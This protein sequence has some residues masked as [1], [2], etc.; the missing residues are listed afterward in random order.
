MS[1]QTVLI[2]EDNELN[3]K[4]AV[5]I[6]EP[7]GYRLLEAADAEAGLEM[8]REHRPDLILMDVQLPGMDGLTAI[9]ILKKDPELKKIPVLVLTSYAMEED[10]KRA[11]DAGADGYVTKPFVI[12]GFRDT[13][14]NLLLAGPAA[15]FATAP[16]RVC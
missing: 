3:M 10:A 8:A 11:R 16:V 4:L 7:E 15:G 9:S 5:A 1:T 6:L 12:Q 13:V 14:R 2:V